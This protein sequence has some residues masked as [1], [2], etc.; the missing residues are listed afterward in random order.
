MSTRR[1]S[2]LDEKMIVVG[3]VGIEIGALAADGDF[4]AAGPPLELVQRVVNRGERDPFSGAH[5]LL[6]QQ[7]GRDMPVAVAKQQRC[8][9]Y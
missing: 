4:R 6:V 2:F 3:C 8:Q 7:F 1:P 9:R 5:G